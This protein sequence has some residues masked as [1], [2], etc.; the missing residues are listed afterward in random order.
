MDS[1]IFKNEF[2][3]STFLNDD[4]NGAISADTWES[5]VKTGKKIALSSFTYIFTYLL[6]MTFH[7]KIF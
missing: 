4:R 3:R 1:I 7:N 2:F 5:E 6:S